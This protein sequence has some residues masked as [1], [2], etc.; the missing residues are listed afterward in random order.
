M[1]IKKN[2]GK[3]EQNENVINELTIENGEINYCLKIYFSKDKKAIIFKVS[4][5][6]IKT[7]YYYE[8]FYPADFQKDHPKYNS[9]NDN[10]TLINIS[11]DIKT[12]IEKNSTKIENDQTNKIKIIFYNDSKIIDTYILRKKILSQN[13]L[14]PILME[15]IKENKIKVKK[16]KKQTD[17]LDKTIKEHEDI[18]NDINTKI[19]NI[20]KKIENIINDINSIKN[21]IKIISK[22]SSKIQENKEQ[23]NKNNKN[24]KNNKKENK[25][26]DDKKKSKC[27]KESFHNLL[28]FFN[29]FIII[30]I[31]YLFIKIN[32][33]EQREQMEKLRKQKSN[34]MSNFI[35]ILESLS[36]N[37]LLEIQS[38]FNSE[39]ITN[40]VDKK[41]TKNEN[42]DENKEINKNKK[43]VGNEI[44]EGNDKINS[45]KNEEI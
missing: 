41:E 23:S 13:R 33:M 22:E 15:E 8:K 40:L 27:N 14:N 19:E 4:Q 26:N 28:I 11:Q 18:I 39:E 7:H 21:T 24:N 12:I 43:H 42:E 2:E 31:A 32:G 38:V 16:N 35:E 6:S 44:K 5:E 3:L 36:E 29:L 20:N 30:L 1:I 25:E 9:I 37:E 45:E 17:K 34:K 10:N